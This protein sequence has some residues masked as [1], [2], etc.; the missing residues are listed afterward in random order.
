MKRFTLYFFVFFIIFLL[1]CDKEN[2]NII[3]D[4]QVLDPDEV[5]LM[6]D[7]FKENDSIHFV[8]ED[9]SEFVLPAQSISKYK[10]DHKDWT[11]TIDYYDDISQTLP[12]FGDS[13]NLQSSD[14]KLNPYGYAP[15]TA[16]LTFDTP[17]PRNVAISVEGKSDKSAEFSKVFYDS[18]VNHELPVYGLYINHNNTI[19]VSILDGLGIPR[20]TRE[21]SIQTKDYDRPQS[22][23]MTVVQ[24]NYSSAQK[25]RLF[26]IQNCIYDGAGDIRWYTTV[27][28]AKFFAQS[29][30]LIAIQVNSDRGS[31]NADP[32]IRVIDYFGRTRQMYF[33]PNRNHHEI[34]EKTPGGNLLVC[35]NAQLFITKD[36]DTEDMIIEIDRS[37]GKI[38][39]EWDLRDI[40]DQY[41]PRIWIEKVNDWCHL[42][43]LQ[44]DSTD[45]TL[46]ISS[47]LQCFISKIDYETGEIKW[48]LGNHNDWKEPWQ[49]YLLTPLNFD[50]SVHPDHD[51]TYVQH[52]PRLLENGNIIVYDNGKERPGGG[53]TR[54]VEFQVD[55]NNM[56]VKKIWSYDLDD[57]AGSLGSIH[58]YDDN[59]V[60]IGHGSKG[61]ILEVSREGE[62]IF[63]G[64][65]KR[66]YRAYPIQ[67]Y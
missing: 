65:L 53:Y 40:F 35:T 48:I 12:F 37:S 13:L 44:Y 64:H 36:D 61:K 15:L 28:G 47:K 18:S 29:N 62:I 34:N 39:R 56:T 58:S 31:D 2:N 24:N 27:V 51:Y 63:E 57:V 60:Q 54:A 43:S 19:Q 7:V 30:N 26:L 50:E 66:F 21:L 14:L 23:F 52:M 8:M 16:N 25:N 20:I 17:Y 1:S 45:N 5:I 42:N 3:V 67:F 9:Q 22:G 6:L 10:I 59:S 46:L 55:P 32:D 49:P 38:I 41:R 11:I 33:V 4:Y